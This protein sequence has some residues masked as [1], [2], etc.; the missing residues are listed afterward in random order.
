MS[1]REVVVALVAHLGLEAEAPP[2]S[3]AFERA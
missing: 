2:R 3:P 1:E